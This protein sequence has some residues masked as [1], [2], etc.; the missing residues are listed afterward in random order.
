[1]RI[2]LTLSAGAAWKKFFIGMVMVE[3]EAVATSPRITMRD[4][5]I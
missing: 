1:V 2:C 5:F 4:L 3:A